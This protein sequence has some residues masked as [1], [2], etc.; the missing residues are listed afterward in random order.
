MKTRLLLI[1]LLLTTGFAFACCSKDH[2]DY[3]PEATVIKAFETKYPKTGKVEWEQKSNYQVAEFRLNGQEAEAW[4]ESNGT[5]MMTETD[6]SLKNLPV[7]VQTAFN[8]SEYKGWKVEDVD[9]IERVGMAVVYII[10]VEQGEQE[11]DLYYAENGALIK[12]VSDEDGNL[13]N[14][15]EP[16]S[17]AIK[18]AIATKYPNAR[19][20]EVDQ[21]KGGIEVDIIDGNIHKEVVF[22]KQNNW[23]S[24]SW[25]VRE[26]N[27]EATVLNA[28]KVSEYK[29]Y[30]IDDIDFYETPAGSYY[31]FEL[32]GN[33]DIYILI[34]LSGKISKR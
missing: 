22:D 20:L 31:Q 32:D 26:A 15:P 10:E 28:F 19:I 17:E 8:A 30:R 23:L 13:Q 4:F 24:T 25:E 2:N 34:D 1:F 7:A 18:N 14:R 6:I 16:L 3:R 27:V 33:P 11:T 12:A 5:W 29:S 21:E 9:Q